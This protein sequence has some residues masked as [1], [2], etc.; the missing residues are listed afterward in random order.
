MQGVSVLLRKGKYQNTPQEA[1]HS[2]PVINGMSVQIKRN[3]NCYTANTTAAMAAT[4][5]SKE[6]TTTEQ[7]TPSMIGICFKLLV[8][9]WHRLEANA[10]VMYGAIPETSNHTRT[11]GK[12]WISGSGST[13]PVRVL[14]LNLRAW[15]DRVLRRR[16]SH[17]TNTQL[18]PAPIQA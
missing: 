7:S 15:R 9:F 1:N 17:L 14:T 16:G 18:T 13:H 6:H 4:H 3:N 5:T 11:I 10:C 2:T 8:Y 12:S